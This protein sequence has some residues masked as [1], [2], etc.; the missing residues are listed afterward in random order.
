MGSEATD[1]RR[2]RGVHPPAD[3]P[4]TA[5]QSASCA[6]ADSRSHA[7]SSTQ[8]ARSMAAG[9][10]NTTTHPAS[11]PRLISPTGTA[12][13]AAS[14]R[15]RHAAESQSGELCAAF[16]EARRRLTGTADHDVGATARR[17]RQALEAQ[18]RQHILD[19]PSYPGRF[20]AP[21]ASRS[22]TSHHR[23]RNCTGIDSSCRLAPR[24]ASRAG[25]VVDQ[26]AQFRFRRRPPIVARA[27][28]A[29]PF[30]IPPLT[31]SRS[32]HA[33]TQWKRGATRNVSPGSNRIDRPLS[34]AG[35]AQAAGS[36]PRRLRRRTRSALRSGGR[37][38]RALH[39]VE[40][41]VEHRLPGQPAEE[42]FGRIERSV[43][44]VLVRRRPA[45]AQSEI[46][47][48]AAAACHALGDRC[49]HRREARRARGGGEGSAVHVAEREVSIF[50]AGQTEEL[51]REGAEV[52][53]AVDRHDGE[54]RGLLQ[55]R[56]LAIG[57]DDRGNLPRGGAGRARCVV[58]ADESRV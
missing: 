38:R 50:G 41:D 40:H 56:R 21:D 12:D 16:V 19:Q 31:R 20:F 13:A 4:D 9:R 44:E 22:A 2:A 28:A 18:K 1:P 11:S 36:R 51:G 57:R 34:S 23:E 7:R 33:A 37:H 15:R 55:T 58:A 39:L 35:A 8:R 26:H 42:G 24:V 17:D 30:S 48:G 54:R 46:G 5:A 32:A 14:S 29:P 10:F 3:S 43:F 25:I 53:V 27:Q 6:S 49:V 45:A 47:T 52:A